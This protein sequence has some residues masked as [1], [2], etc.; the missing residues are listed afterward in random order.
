MHPTA[1]STAHGYRCGLAIG[2]GAVLRISSPCPR[3]TVPDVDQ[4]TGAVDA[5]AAAPIATL[6]GYRARAGRGVLF[7]AYTSALTP[8]ATIHVGAPVQVQSC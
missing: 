6:R 5:A 1:S 2:S 4:R 8:D 7:G 3:C